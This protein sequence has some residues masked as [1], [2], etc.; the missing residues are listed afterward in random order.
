MNVYAG[1]GPRRFVTV[2]CSNPRLP[3]PS[4]H[5]MA[6]ISYVGREN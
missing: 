3:L 1:V 2:T 5:L 6:R 4:R